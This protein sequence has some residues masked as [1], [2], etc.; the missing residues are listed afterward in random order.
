MDLGKTI[1]Q[2]YLVHALMLHGI[3]PNRRIPANMH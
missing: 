1:M 3:L 2:D